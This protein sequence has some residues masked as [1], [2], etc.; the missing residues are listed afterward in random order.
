MDGWGYGSAF[1]IIFWILI[2][3][4]V[5]TLIWFLVQKGS[6]DN[7]SG[8]SALDILKKRYSRGE[9]DEEEYQRKKKQL[10]E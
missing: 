2:V 10:N 7:T 1:M 3:A 6:S 4:L 9:I 8:E 5:I